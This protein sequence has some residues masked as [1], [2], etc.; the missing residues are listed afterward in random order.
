MAT[1]TMLSSYTMV[2]PGCSNAWLSLSDKWLA[3]TAEG[4]KYSMFILRYSHY[5]VVGIYIPRFPNI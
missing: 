4:P 3:N 5:E 1:V 2:A